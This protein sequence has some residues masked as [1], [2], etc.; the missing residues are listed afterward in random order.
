MTSLE[1]R[2]K[3]LY[4]FQIEISLVPTPPFLSCF[5]VNALHLKLILDT[6]FQGLNPKK[7]KVKK[8]QGTFSNLG[9]IFSANTRLL[10]S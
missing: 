8:F 7:K 3:L 4:K 9:E 1:T 2:K 10:S 5:T 6:L